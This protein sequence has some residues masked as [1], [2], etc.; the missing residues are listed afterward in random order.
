MSSPAWTEVAT[1]AQAR[2]T[3]RWLRKAAGP[4][5]AHY[6][7]LLLLLV[8]AFDAYVNLSAAILE[9]PVCVGHCPQP[10]TD[11]LDWDWSDLLLF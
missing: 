9:E 5:L 3:R 8:A 10:P 4:I 1:G 7:V 2:S 11:D 6:L